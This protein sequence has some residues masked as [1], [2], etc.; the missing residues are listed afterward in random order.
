MDDFTLL[1]QNTQQVCMGIMLLIYSYLFFS[2]DLDRLRDNFTGKEKKYLLSVFSTLAIGLFY[3]F[4][5]EWGLSGFFYSIEFT[6][7]IVL[8]IIH[9]KYAAGLLIY[10]LLSRPWETSD[11]Q[12]LN[13]MP[14]DISYLVMLSIIAHKILNKKFYFRFNMGTLILLTFAVWLFLSGFFSDHSSLAIS[15]YKESFTKVVVL[16]LLIQNSIDYV[17]DAYPLK[18]ALIISILEKGFITFYSTYFSQTDTL[19]GASE[20]LVSIGILQNSNDIA[21][22]FTLVI[23]F[24][25]FFILKTK[26]K[27]FS[28]IFALISFWALGSLVWQTQSRGSVIGLVLCLASYF[29]LKVKNKKIL[30]VGFIFSLIASFAMIQMMQRSASDLD[31]STNNR[32]IF[33]K[34]GANMAIRNPVFGVGFWGFNR[35]LSSY[36]I[37][38]DLGSEGGDMTA[39]SSWVLVLAEGGFMALF[40]FVSLWGYAG[41]RAW[42]LRK[43]EPEYFMA[44]VGYGVAVTFLSHTYLLFP[45]ILLG[46]IIS[47]SKSDDVVIHYRLD[48]KGSMN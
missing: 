27:P 45:Y 36:A 24:V 39:H 34:A 13:S 15:K 32:V 46:I 28:W 10:L 9:P 38:G 40:L 37:G 31:G 48:N 33:W 2:V 8:A 29:V 44:L 42:L 21:A 26:L 12:I 3:V 5:N 19:G 41:Y 35:N 11:N 14:R 20:R 7:L 18:I 6:L 4:S 43:S 30:L 25:I 22:I 23:P 17:K 16:F 47:H 1:I